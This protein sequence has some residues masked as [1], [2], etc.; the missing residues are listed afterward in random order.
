MLLL[1]TCSI[2]LLKKLPR[3]TTVVALIFLLTAETT[4]PNLIVI[5]H[6][7]MWVCMFAAVNY[8]FTWLHSGFIKD[9]PIPADGY[10]TLCNI[11]WRG[12]S[13]LK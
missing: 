2:Y 9:K 7:W 4:Q 3:L 11:R 8:S 12:I 10:F 6:T 1:T 13:A 5:P